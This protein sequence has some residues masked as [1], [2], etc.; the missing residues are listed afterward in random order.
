MT[1]SPLHLRKRVRRRPG[2]E[3]LLPTLEG[4]P[5]AYLV[6]GAVRE[7]LRGAEPVDVDIALQGDARSAASS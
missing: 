5:P 7:L 2:M 1:E 3:R 4:L 6:G